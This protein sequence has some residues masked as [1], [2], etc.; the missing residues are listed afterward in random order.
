VPALVVA[1][2]QDEHLTKALVEDLFHVVACVAVSTRWASEWSAVERWIE[3]ASVDK[4]GAG[5][6]CGGGI[7]TVGLHAARI[8]SALTLI[9]ATALRN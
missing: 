4:G 7:S 5:F 3:A 6:W 8:G 2:L 9:E 1:F